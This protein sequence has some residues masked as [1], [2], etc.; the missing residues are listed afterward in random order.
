MSLYDAFLEDFVLIEKRKIADPEGGWTTQWE[1][2]ATFKAT[3]EFSTSIEARRAQAQGVTSAYTVTT[4]TA[5]KLEYHDVFK[6]IR[7]GK[8][9]RA[10]S[11]GDDK[12]TPR[13]ASAAMPQMS[14]VTAEEWALT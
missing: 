7:D 14:I 8:I 4:P 6:R 10:T 2:G 12:I 5:T 13:A 3:V 1:E 11:D 9:F